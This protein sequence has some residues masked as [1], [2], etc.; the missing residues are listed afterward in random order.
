MSMHATYKLDDRDDEFLAWMKKETML[1]NGQYDEIW[2][3]DSDV[4]KKDVVKIQAIWPGRFAD[5][6]YKTGVF[7]DDC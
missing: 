4:A 1:S 2:Y 5:H 3:V 6:K 7:I